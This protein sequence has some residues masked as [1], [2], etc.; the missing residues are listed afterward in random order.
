MSCRV[1]LTRDSDSAISLDDRTA[2]ANREKADLF[3][4]IH[5]NSSRTAGARG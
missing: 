2:V 1:L 4:S 5:A 3:L